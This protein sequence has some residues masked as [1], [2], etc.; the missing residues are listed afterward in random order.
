M[1]PLKIV[2]L[3]EYLVVALIKLK[4]TNPKRFSVNGFINTWILHQIIMY[5][6]K[7]KLVAGYNN[8]PL[9]STTFPSSPPELMNE[10]TNKL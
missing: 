2:H 10:L 7:V 6:N 8:D 9:P 3:F 4:S 5:S 1:T